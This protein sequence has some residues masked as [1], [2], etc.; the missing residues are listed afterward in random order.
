MKK[1][2]VITGIGI[3]SP[4]GNDKETFANGLKQGKSGAAQIVSF[5]TTEFTTH[6][7]AEVKDFNPE[8]YIEKKKIRRMAKN[9]APKFSAIIN[10]L[11]TSKD[12]IAMASICGV[13]IPVMVSSWDV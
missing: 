2:V 10:P 3:I 1:R 12:P 11:M 8:N 5:D 13:D 6:I 4:I 9:R 7:G